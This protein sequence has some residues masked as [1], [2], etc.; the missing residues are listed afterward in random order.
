MFSLE[1][2]DSTHIEVKSRKHSFHYAIDGSLANPLE[3][4][5]AA[6]AGCAGV[7]TLKACK[8]LK[9]DP[10]GIKISGKPFLDKINPMLLSKWISEVSFPDGWNEEDKK[11]VLSE[12]ENCAVKE[13]IKNGLDIEFA[14][15]ENLEAQV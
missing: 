8:K 4:T 12:I 11:H 13:L 9:L 15:V 2:T 7:Y 14:T 6:L 5:Y 1:L 3:A 10:S